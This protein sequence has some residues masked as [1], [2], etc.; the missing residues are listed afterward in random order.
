MLERLID[1]LLASVAPHVCLA[2]QREGALLC[3]DCVALL[4]DI[5]PSC[6]RCER[7]GS[8]KVCEQCREHVALRRVQIMTPYESFAEALLQAYKFERVYNAHRQI[9]QVLTSAP[10]PKSS[11][12]VPVPTITDHVRQ[13]GYDHALKITQRLG[14]LTGLPTAQLLERTNQ[15]SQT[16]KKRAERLSQLDG[17][18]ALRRTPPKNVKIVLIDDVMT[19][20][21]TLEQC[22]RVLRAA[23]VKQISA[24]AFARASQG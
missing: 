18:I 1:P 16:G 11:L 19:T 3:T 14:K 7:I 10:Y 17:A 8:W 2:C 24:V 13:R 23:G 15:V 6:Y 9:A 12:L 21:A 22:A 5:E 4:S 20:G